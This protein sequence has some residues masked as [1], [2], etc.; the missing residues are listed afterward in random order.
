MERG[1]DRES[2]KDSHEGMCIYVNIPYICKPM[3]TY[4]CLHEKCMF[5]ASESISYVS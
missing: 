3:P 4:E 2:N 1:A 5:Y